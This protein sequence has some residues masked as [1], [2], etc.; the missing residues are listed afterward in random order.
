[1]LPRNYRLTAYNNSGSG[2]DITVTVRRWKFNSSG[3]VVYEASEATLL[4][5]TGTA[6]TTLAVPA[7]GEDNSTDAYI[8]MSGVMSLAN[9]TGTGIV[10]LLLEP[11]TD[12]GTSWP[13]AED[14]IPLCSGVPNNTDKVAFTA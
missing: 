9:G 13:T 6:N 7:S 12:G 1:M 8:G 10:T 5:T 2:V 3:A 4:S 14:A 11:S